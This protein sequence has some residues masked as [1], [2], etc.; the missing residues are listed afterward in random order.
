MKAPSQRDWEDNF[1][2]S[3]INSRARRE[4]AARRAEARMWGTLLG[5]IAALGII[6]LFLMEVGV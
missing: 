4:N 1:Q 6:G 3:L 5:L 2:R